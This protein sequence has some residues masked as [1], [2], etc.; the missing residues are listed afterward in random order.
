[1]AGITFTVE[2]STEA[3][4]QALSDLADPMARPIGFYRSAGAYLVDIAIP[5]NF[6]TESEPDGTPWAVLSPLTVARRGSTGPILRATGRMAASIVSQVS[7]TSLR[8]GSPVEQAAV[9][10]LGAAQGAFGRTSR[11]GPIPWGTIPARPFLGLSGADEV[12]I[13]KIAEDWLEVE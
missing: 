12:E 11:G 5:R 9:M 2:L 8:I 6:S 1:M 3:A 10:Q 4:A 13:I 7:G